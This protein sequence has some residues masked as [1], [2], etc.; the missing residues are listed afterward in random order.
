MPVILLYY[1]Y[2]LRITGLQEVITT[3][4]SNTHLIAHAAVQSGPD[5]LPV[6]AVTAAG[7]PLR[8]RS[9]DFVVTA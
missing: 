2:N 1:M 4:H 7:G 8:S 9:A 3:W 5:T 6:S